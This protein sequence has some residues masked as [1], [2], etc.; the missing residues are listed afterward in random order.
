MC[1]ISFNKPIKMIAEKDIPVVKFVYKRQGGYQSVYYRYPY[2]I[3]DEVTSTI[4][5][6]GENYIREGLHS[7]IPCS[8]YLEGWHSYY[9][10]VKLK[11]SCF[12]VDTLFS[13]YDDGSTLVQM[14]CIIPKGSE[15]YVNERGE[16]VSNKL[17]VINFEEICVG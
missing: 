12:N 4:I 17:K 1:W 11:N 9:I 8:I 5:F 10:C 14:N 7:Y 15:Y 13:E 3:G 6:G 16:V 2:K